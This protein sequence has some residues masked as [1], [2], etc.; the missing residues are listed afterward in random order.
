MNNEAWEKLLTIVGGYHL[1][2]FTNYTIVTIE[3]DHP[4]D[5]E[6][7]TKS[8]ANQAIEI[9]KEFG[10]VEAG[11]ISADINP[12]QPLDDS[13]EWWVVSYPHCNQMF[14]IIRMDLEGAAPE[15]LE[16]SSAVIAIQGREA[17][18]KDVL[19]PVIVA[20]EKNSP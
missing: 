2:A 10:P 14:N 3:S 8:S 9:L 17:R 11:T 13:N 7:P 5:D 6:Q 4:D 19:D 20:T 12:P 16:S 1:F 18:M 15:N